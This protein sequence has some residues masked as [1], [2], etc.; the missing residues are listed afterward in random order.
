MSTGPQGR[1]GRLWLRQRITAAEAALDLLERKL[2]ILR[3]EQGRLHRLAD[4]TGGEWRRRCREADRLLVRAALLG[5][6]R[7]LPLAATGE[8]AGLTVEHATLMGVSYPG[9]IRF[10][11]ADRPAPSPSGIALAPARRACRA[12]LDAACAHAA[13]AAAAATVDAEVAATRQRIRAVERRR[14]P[15]LRAALGRIEV[16]LEERE[17]EDGARLRLIA[18]HGDRGR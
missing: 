11:V 4:R 16:A 15:T 17:R 9:R 3:D 7:V 18:G 5:G 13:A 2:A 10:E 12:A 1:A 14:L 8:Q 6:R